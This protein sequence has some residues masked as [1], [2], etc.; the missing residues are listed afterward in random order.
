MCG[1]AV[2][3]GRRLTATALGES[4]VSPHFRFDDRLGDV[5][6]GLSA[7]LARQARTPD[8]FALRASV[9]C[10]EARHHSASVQEPDQRGNLALT[11]GEVRALR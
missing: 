3:V 7:L 10:A 6:S 2:V 5:R 8:S 1:K 11:F 9:H 4:M